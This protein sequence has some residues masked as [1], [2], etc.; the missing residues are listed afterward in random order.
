M[1]I[2]TKKKKNIEKQEK[3]NDS[4]FETVHY[5]PKFLPASKK[6][7]KTAIDSR[8]SNLFNDKNFKIVSEKDK[9]GR[10]IDISD[11]NEDME[12]LYYIN[13]AEIPKEHSISEKPLK[14]PKKLKIFYLSSILCILP[15]VF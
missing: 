7:S 4:R 11:K 8:F 15:K 9:Y 3:I 12:R 6:V 13:D 2:L 5:D 1:K 10:T 14:K